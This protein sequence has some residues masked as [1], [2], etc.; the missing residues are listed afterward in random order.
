MLGMMDSLS[1]STQAALSGLEARLLAV[2][3]K[4]VSCLPGLPTSLLHRKKRKEKKR[5]RLSASN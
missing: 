5:L 4:V 3:A 2:E 1:V